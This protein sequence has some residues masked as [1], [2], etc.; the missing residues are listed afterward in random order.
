MNVSPTL[1]GQT[2]EEKAAKIAANEIVMLEED[3]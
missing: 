3:N 2:P 1:I